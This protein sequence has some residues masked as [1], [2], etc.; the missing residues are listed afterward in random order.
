M[1]HPFEVLR[2]E[3]ERLLATVTVTRQAAVKQAADTVEHHIDAYKRLAEAP[4]PNMPP[5][6]LTGALDY[7]ESDCNQ[8]CGIGQGDRWDRVSRHVPAGKGPFASKLEA[9]RYYIHYDHL[10]DLS[11]DKWTMAYACWKGE[12]WNGFG[13]RGHGVHSPYLWGGT[14]I[15]QRG[16]Y[17]ADGVWD[18]AAMDSQVGIVPVMLELIHRDPSLAFGVQ[19]PVVIGEEPPAVPGPVPVGVGGGALVMGGDALSGTRWI[20]H[21]MNLLTHAGLI[22]D[23]SYGRRTREAVRAFQAAQGLEPDGLAGP[24]TCAAIDAGLAALK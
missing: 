11:V 12:I 21:A 5:A 1:Q 2:P 9:D 22:E 17:V 4:P 7:R 13:Y 18:S 10:D 14:N 6:V 19:I 24:K 8:A 3:Y 20:Q 16:K 23:G 15:Q